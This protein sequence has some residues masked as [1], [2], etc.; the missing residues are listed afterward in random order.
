VLKS[1]N[2]ELKTRFGI[3]LTNRTGVNTG[4]VVATDDPTRDQK[5]ATGD[6]VNVT[7][8][9]ESAA[10]ANEIYIGEVTYRL[11]RDAVKVEAVEPLTLKGKS[12]PVPAFRLISVH[13][14]DGNVRRHDTPLVG[15]DA[16]LAALDAAWQEALGERRARL[17]TVIG[18]AGAGKTR[19]VRETMER[20]SA[21][22]RVISGRCL[23]YG[24][25]ITFWPLRGMVIA[26]AGIRDDD[27]P[28]EAR[29]RIFDCVHDQDVADRLA[30]ATGLST[31]AFP[32][33]EINWGARKF[34]QALAAETPVVALF[35]D[36]HW[37]E[38]AFLD[39]MENLLDTIEGAPVLLLATARH[40][41]LEQRPDWSEREGARRLVLKPLADDAVA[42]VIGNLLGAAGL[43][44]SFVSR[45]VVAAEGNPLYVEQML[46]MLIDTGVVREIDGQWI[47]AKTDG[48]IAI[49][50][51][52]QALLE[53]R[54]DKLDRG[55][56]AAAEPAAVIGLEFARPAVQSLSPVAMREGVDD[57][58]QSLSRKHFIRP[59]LSVDGEPLYRFD[60]H[61]V[62]ETVYNGLLKRARA[63][64]HVDFV[65]WSD[66]VNADCDRGREFEAILGYHLEQAYRY[67]SELG[68]IDP[69]GAAIGSD[70]AQRLASAGHR[71]FGRGDMHAAV[72]L[73]RRSTA[74]LP[75]THPDRLRL[76]PDLGEGLMQLGKFAEAK[77]LLE[78]AA[79]LAEQT[80]DIRVKA[81]ARLVGMFVRLYGG[82]SGD[83]GGQALRLAREVIPEL[84]TISA[85]DELAVAWRLI[86]FV[87]GV[88]GRY[89]ESAQAHVEYMKHARLA[90]NERLV[91]R[92]QR[93]VAMCA[94]LG[95]TP[96]P[97][98]IVLCEQ[99]S[100]N[101]SNDRQVQSV[102]ACVLAQL[103]AMNGEYDAARSLYRQGRALLRDLGSSVS[104]SGTAIDAARVEVMAGDLEAAE[105]ELRADF[106]FLSSSG[107]TYLLSTLAAVLSR[108]VRDRGDDAEAMA[109]SRVAEQATADDDVEPQVLWRVARA[110]IVA[111]AGNPTE[112]EALART[113]VALAA[114][115]DAPVLRAETLF[116]LASVLSLAGKPDAAVEAISEA[117]ALYSMKG[118]LSSVERARTAARG[119]A[120][121]PA[122]IG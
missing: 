5:L 20:L 58:L 30:A 107:E 90:G 48:E 25:G 96:V 21:R 57:K 71:A 92:S 10:P 4:E 86:G 108:I 24:D 95:P 79:E 103:R 98:A 114:R 19:L 42:Q 50:A 12:Q 49:P 16:E 109:L 56:R 13:G 80:S 105:C 2:A 8:R 85:H 6:A 35:D 9:L 119:L 115:T 33:H 112:A 87:H 31:T 32:L 116:E 82:E 59:W 26:A 72:N 1:V 63:S 11:V 84:E 55:E 68:P 110:S 37:A 83:W 70:G 73:L 60:H 77:E 117:I 18:D 121:G 43:P 62:R 66:E 40:E 81:A 120:E 61:L 89:G 99:M 97:E 53:A 39:L 36:I 45:V 94:L 113:A 106:E 67:L 7:A 91:A 78:Q 38:P 76:M 23:P 52:I 122:R 47:A 74:L 51:T 22:A 101:G 41:L 29:A 3:E 75:E 54:L 102:I 14:E 15:R 111:R 104:S 65:R 69:V 27:G 118:D 64:M 46:S 17:V 44:E 100:A 93:G 88:A 34:F 28:E